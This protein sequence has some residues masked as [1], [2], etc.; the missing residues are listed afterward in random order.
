MKELWVEKYRPPTLDG[1]VFKDK[2]QKKQIERWISGG[3]LP[4]MLLSGSPGTG[5]STLI[6]VLLNELG[7][8]PFDVLQVNASKDNGVDFIRDTITKFSE[9]MGYGEI[10]YVFLDEAD[11]LSPS[12]QGT[13]RGTMEKYATSV[14]FLLTCNYPHKLIQA[15]HSRCE[16][17][18]MHI[19]NLNKDEFDMRLIDILQ[20][21]SIELDFDALEAISKK[22]YPDLRRGISMAQANSLDGKLQTPGEDTEDVSDYRLE[23]VVLFKDKKFKLARQLIC[24]QVQQEEYEDIYRFMYENLQYWSDGDSGKEDRCI[25]AIRDGLVK[26]TLCSDSELNLSATF[27]EL[28]RIARGEW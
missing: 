23:M 20:K 24:T 2:N 27:V 10:R 1:Y 18:R 9:T 19:E 3:A 8:D 12:A 4:H 13:L 15:I 11:G 6:K 25:M 21:E 16:T 7:V 5:K 22:T 17:G 26:H 28:E 14:R